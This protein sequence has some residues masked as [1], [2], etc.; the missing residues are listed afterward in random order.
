MNNDSIGDFDY[1]ISWTIEAPHQ[2]KKGIKIRITNKSEYKLDAILCE[3]R[4][5]KCIV[6]NIVCVFKNDISNIDNVVIAKELENLFTLERL[7]N[8]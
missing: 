3:S 8:I 5:T 4:K 1:S 6:S 7:R 2:N